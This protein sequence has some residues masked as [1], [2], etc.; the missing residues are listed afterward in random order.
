MPLAFTDAH[1]KFRVPGWRE[2]LG[3]DE[4]IGAPEMVRHFLATGETGSGK[5]V[6]AVMPLLRATL[7]YPENDLYERYSKD[8]GDAAERQA[9]L[10]PSVL[11]VD[12]KE[13]LIDVVR[14]EARGRRVIRVTYGEPGPVLHLFEGRDLGALEA[15][16]AL[17]LILQQS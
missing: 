6:S 10:R 17:N 7:R 12:P 2:L 13:E 16:E 9:D 15:H 3:R 1:P 5:S 8:A 11:A 14:R 4:H